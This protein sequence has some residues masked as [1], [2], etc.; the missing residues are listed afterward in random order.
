MLRHALPN[1]S[2]VKSA[3]F[4]YALT[5]WDPTRGDFSGISLFPWCTGWVGINPRARALESRNR[6]SDFAVLGKFTFVG[7]RNKMS[8]CL[9]I[10]LPLRNP[11]HTRTKDV[12]ISEIGLGKSVLLFRGKRCFFRRIRSVPSVYR[13]VNHRHGAACTTD[14]WKRC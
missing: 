13:T 5:L 1:A 11:A 8:V 14:R 2:M 12:F 9:A 3:C 6:N 4:M 7:L 10:L